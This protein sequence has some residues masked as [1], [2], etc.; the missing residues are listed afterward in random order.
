MTPT[1]TTKKLKPAANRD[2]LLHLLEA[3]AASAR[4]SA[5]I[6]RLRAAI[7]QIQRNPITSGSN[8]HDSN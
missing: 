2:R 5:L 1:T 3:N 6:E 7:E 8:A 4:E